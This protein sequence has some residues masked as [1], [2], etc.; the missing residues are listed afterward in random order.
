MRGGHMP[1]K[2]FV[3]IMDCARWK[4]WWI[5]WFEVLLLRAPAAHGVSSLFFC[6]FGGGSI[7]FSLRRF[8]PPFLTASNFNDLKAKY[9]V[10]TWML[11]I[12]HLCLFKKWH[13]VEWPLIVSLNWPSNILC[14]CFPLLIGF[15]ALQAMVTRFSLWPQ[16]STAS[17]HWAMLP[18]RRTALQKR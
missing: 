7:P 11:A 8:A 14:T 5:E 1:L 18:S 10:G 3:I 12:F 16:L 17:P 9:D 6:R 2:E 15:V 13:N 4:S